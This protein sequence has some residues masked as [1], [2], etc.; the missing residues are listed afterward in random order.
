[1]Q[2]IR[3]NSISHE[4]NEIMPLAVTWMD[5]KVI[6]LILGEVRQRVMN[7]YHYSWNVK[8]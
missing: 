7:V 6:L 3:W 2:N 8:K 4:K 1:M 5:L